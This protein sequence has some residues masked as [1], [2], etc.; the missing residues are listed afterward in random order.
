MTVST[1]S[2]VK[3]RDLRDYAK[4]YASQSYRFEKNMQRMRYARIGGALAPLF[5]QFA[6][7]RRLTLVEPTEEFY[8]AAC[9]ARA[10]L[11]PA[12]AKRVDIVQATME[13][14][15]ETLTGRDFDFALAIGM[16][17]EVPNDN[18]FLAAI[19]H[20]LPAG[21]LLLINVPNAN[22]FHRLLAVEMGL[23]K[24]VHAPSDLQKILQQPRLYDM[25]TL[26]EQVQVAGFA[27]E[28]A[29]TRIIKPFTHLQ[30]A[31]LQDAGILTPEM[32]RG[33]ES[34]SRHLPDMGAEINLLA[35]AK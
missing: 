23:I 17:H 33:L 28:H 14:A 31:Q 4:Q 30:M 24:S 1:S 16:L 32:E 11:A 29:E 34:M 5:A 20:V 26:R 10:A 9:R 2:Q 8:L 7:Y 25:Q 21:A 3:A 19:R 22:A 18:A 12:R 6:G 15:S 27:V 13:D 35:R